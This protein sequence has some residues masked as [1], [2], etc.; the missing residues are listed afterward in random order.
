MEL[1]SESHLKMKTAKVG[2]LFL[3]VRRDESGGPP[4]ERGNLGTFNEENSSQAVFLQSAPLV[5]QQDF[6]HDTKYIKV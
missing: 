6:Q 3:V 1:N 2:P 5:S 4:A